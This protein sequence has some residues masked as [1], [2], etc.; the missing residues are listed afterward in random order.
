[1]GR[2]ASS[3]RRFGALGA[4]VNRRVALKSGEAHA[5]RGA[6]TEPGRDPKLVDF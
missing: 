5:W 3:A 4:L 2:D 6:T 1:M